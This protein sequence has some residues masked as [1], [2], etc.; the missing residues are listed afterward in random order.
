MSAPFAVEDLRA[1]DQPSTVE[2]KETLNALPRLMNVVH[3][4]RPA[5]ILS[6]VVLTPFCANF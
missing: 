5:F 1:G 3:K 4:N 6:V 2:R